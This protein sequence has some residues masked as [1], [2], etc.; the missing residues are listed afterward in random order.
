VRSKRDLITAWRP[1]GCALLGILLIAGAVSC[2]PRDGERAASPSDRPRP[3]APPAA[4]QV[5]PS[6]AGVGFD[7]L[8]GRWLRA[9]GG[10]VLEIRAVSPEGRV[11]ASYLNPRPINVARAEAGRGGDIVTLLVELR[12]VNYPG[13]T[14]RLWYDA[15]RDILEGTYF[16]AAQQQTFDVAFER[17]A[18]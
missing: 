14:Y 17:Q 12:D 9:D 4:A 15:G 18:R 13:S 6:R 3:A 1:A 2:G 5:S 16:Q 8:V 10:Y 7:R 11:E